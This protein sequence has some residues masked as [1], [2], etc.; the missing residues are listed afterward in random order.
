VSAITP[1]ADARAHHGIIACEQSLVGR[2][3]P[4]EVAEAVSRSLRRVSNSLMHTPSLRAQELAR[5]GDLDDYRRAMHTLFGIDVPA[6][7][8][9]A[10]ACGGLAVVRLER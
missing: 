2:K 9:H 8:D 5:T 3:Y 6:A 10:V 7:P 4:P 1:E